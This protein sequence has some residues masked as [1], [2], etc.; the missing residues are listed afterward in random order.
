MF[1][2]AIITT[3]GNRPIAEAL[4]Q[5]THM[6]IG[7][8][9]DDIELLGY[10]GITQCFNHDQQHFMGMVIT[11]G[12]GSVRQGPYANTSNQSL[13][14]IRSHEQKAA[15][16]IGRYAVLI[17]LQLKSDDVKKN[18]P[19]LIEF[20]Q[21]CLDQSNVTTLYTHNPFDRHSTHLGVLNKTIIAIL[22][23]QRQPHLKAA[24]GVEV[25]RSLDWLPAQ[26]RIGLDVSARPHLAA[27]LMGVYDSQ[28]AG[29][30]RYDLAA[31][32]RRW[33]NA[34]FGDAH[35]L[36]QSTEVQWACDLL[37]IVRGQYT[38]D[39]YIEQVTTRYF[40]QLQQAWQSIR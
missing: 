27:A 35:A 22:N 17:E 7:T 13:I 28:I 4:G 29:G 11:S 37:P 6:T 15:A 10:H 24:Y 19:Q 5:C 34:T 25:W 21:N 18:N 38:V 9:P 26:Y 23:S 36:D 3:A 20:I 33:A 40:Q 31:Q 30:K 32:G 14:E 39:D 1:E 16:Q 12:A 8:H 2:Q